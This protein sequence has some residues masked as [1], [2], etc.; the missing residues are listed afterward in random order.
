MTLN[1]CN[2]GHVFTYEKDNGEVAYWLCTSV[3]KINDARKPVEERV[4]YS[5]DGFSSEGSESIQD[6][7]GKITIKTNNGEIVFNITAASLC[8]LSKFKNTKRCGIV[9]NDVLL[10]VYE[11]LDYQTYIKQCKRLLESG[12]DTFAGAIYDCH[13]D[14]F[15]FICIEYV[16]ETDMCNGYM[17]N[18]DDMYAMMAAH[19]SAYVKQFKF[20]GYLHPETFKFYREIYNH[21]GDFSIEH[22]L[23]NVVFFVSSKP[24]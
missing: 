20:I 4:Y 8:N 16:P 5:F 14:K 19:H 15:F 3:E 21:S 6:K 12:F 10:K 23:K 1:D 24:K 11:Q 22:P 13:D 18:K 17:I 2:I 7:Y 9:S